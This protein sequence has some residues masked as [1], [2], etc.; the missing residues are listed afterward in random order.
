MQF[1]IL[2]VDDCE[3]H[4]QLIVGLLG[5]QQQLTHAYTLSEA[6][7]FLELS[8]F[9][10]IL[11]DITLPDG[12]GLTFYGDLLEVEKT[13]GLPVIFITGHLESNK[14]VMGFSLG[15]D[16]F[17]TKPIDPAR[18]KARIECRLKQIEF[19]K[20]KDLVLVR[21]NL[22]LCVTLQKVSILKEGIEQFIDL[23][24]VEFK[25]LFHFLRH[26]NFILTREQLL[27]AVWGDAAEVLD[28]TIDMHISNLRKKISESHFKI[29]AIHG[30]GY[31]LMN[32]NIG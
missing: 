9:D 19:K 7:K 8:P 29:K 2:V 21:G 16:D 32:I 11:L 31:K 10:L 6:R 12:D 25:L 15:A 26:E 1:K 23:T 4:Q 13:R 17:I 22:R 28:R 24:P 20:D 14:E 27:K 30:T 3:E 18:F 5:K